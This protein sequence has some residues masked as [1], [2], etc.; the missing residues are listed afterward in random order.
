MWADRRI[1]QLICDQR[2]ESHRLQAPLW[3]GTSC[4]LWEDRVLENSQPG[5]LLAHPQPVYEM[6]GC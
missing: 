1:A 5:M 6:Q 3:Q 2:P 4:R